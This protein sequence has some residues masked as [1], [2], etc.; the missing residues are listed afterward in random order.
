MILIIK[1]NLLTDISELVERALPD[2]V[3][4]RLVGFGYQLATGNLI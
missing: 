2:F 3:A 1:L 4:R